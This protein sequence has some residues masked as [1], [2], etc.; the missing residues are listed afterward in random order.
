MLRKDWLEVAFECHVLA[1]KY[2]VADRDRKTKTL[3]VG[4]ADAQRKAGS[5]H[6]L[7]QN[8]EAEHLCSSA[9]NCVFIAENADVP[10]AERFD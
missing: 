9:I 3:I 10:E 5:M 7:V 1:H 8:H 2:L 4:V 6:A